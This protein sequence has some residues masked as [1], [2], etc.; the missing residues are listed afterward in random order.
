M[1]QPPRLPQ[2]RTLFWRVFWTNATVLT[3]VCAI[4]EG[5]RLRVA[6]ELHDEVGQ[7]LTS[8]VLQLGRTAARVPG[9]Y[10]SE[11]VDA[12]EIARSSLEEVRRIALQLRP[13]ALDD[14]GLG[15]R[16][17]IGRRRQMLERMTR[18]VLVRP[19]A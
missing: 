1:R 8:V 4:T 9:E 11:V 14:L 3:A 12:Q 18:P 19:V 15:E 6:Q 5:E 16:D 7:T 17:L 10:R 13:E 2:R